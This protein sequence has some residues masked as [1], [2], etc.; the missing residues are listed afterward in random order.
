VFGAPELRRVFYSLLRRL[1]RYFGMVKTIRLKHHA[2][3]KASRHLTPIWVNSAFELETRNLEPV[4]IIQ[5]R[6]VSPIIGP[7][8]I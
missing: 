6:L 2:M 5:L 8:V 3:C 1:S 4:T 7:N